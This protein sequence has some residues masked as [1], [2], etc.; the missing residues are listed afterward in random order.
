[1]SSPSLST[2]VRERG[3]TLANR[4]RVIPGA[5]LVIRIIRD[6]AVND[7][8]DRAMTLAAQ[9]FTSILPIVILLTALPDQTFITTAL[10]GLGVDPDRVD[11][12]S[13]ATPGSAT[14]IGV[15]GALMTIAGATS[16]S[17]ALGRMYVSVWQVTKLPISGWWRWVV[18]IFV[19]PVGVVLQGLASSLHHVTL[20]GR[21]LFG[22]Y[23]IV[24]LALEVVATFLIWTLLW[25][26]V[27]RLLVSAQVPMRLLALDGVVSGLFITILLIGSRLALP[28]ILSE[29]T[30][31]YGTLGAVF[32]AISWLFFYAAIVVV[33][34]I[35]VHTLVTDDGFVGA[36]IRRHAG[37]THPFPI[38]PSE[39]LA[40]D[41]FRIDPPVHDA[42]AER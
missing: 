7:V 20:N 15:L 10:S 28:T 13:D 21:T 42:P 27:P 26:V 32:V 5:Y 14:A 36:W 22:G 1:M 4:A 25:T 8:T 33:S 23:S 30:K 39:F 16:L 34:A 11:L 38:R 31:H 3:V 37:T 24:G 41:A 6:L 40:D 19:F 2:R 17:R 9:A 35:V 18:V 12:V 29:T